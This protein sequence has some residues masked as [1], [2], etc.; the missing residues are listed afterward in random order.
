MDQEIEKN[1]ENVP[2][3]IEQSNN[4]INGSQINSVVSLKGI[5]ELVSESFDVYRKRF[6]GLM[7]MFFSFVIAVLIL[8]LLAVVASLV[9]SVFAGES[10][11]IS[12]FVRIFLICV[13]FLVYI[14]GIFWFQLSFA[15][16][17]SNE[18]G[19]FDSYKNTWNKLGGYFW[20]ISLQGVITLGA[21]ALLIVP[22]IIVFIWFSFSLF[23]FINE[24]E[25]GLN[26]LLRSYEYV[27]GRWGA[28]FTRIAIPN[29][30]LFLF[31][32]ACGILFGKN[33]VVWPFIN[34]LIAPLF[35]VYSF[36]LYKNLKEVRGEVGCYDQDKRKLFIG[37]SIWG[38]LFSILFP[39]CLIVL[40]IISTGGARGAARDS[41]VRANIDQMRTAA[42]LYKIRTTKTDYSGME[43]DEDVSRLIKETAGTLVPSNP[44]NDWCYVVTLSDKQRWCVDSNNY[45]GY[46]NNVSCVDDSHSCN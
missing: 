27:K 35:L 15:Y 38:L 31:G 21:F 24:N 9:V 22:G 19:I 17:V 8:V 44:V 30:F 37:F 2:I 1:E 32:V 23:I 34:I 42:S 6:W 40:L 46:T 7:G 20:L 12:I 25:K 45:S 33:N 29:L 28:I 36:S 41:L 39:I 5:H 26:V 13:S 43:A 16:Y 10:S 3:V 11:L 4:Q 18:V 14:V